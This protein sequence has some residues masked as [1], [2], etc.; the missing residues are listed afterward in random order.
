VGFERMKYRLLLL[1]AIL[2]AFQQLE[3]DITYWVWER[4]KPLSNEELADLKAARVTRL[5]WQVGTLTTDGMGWKWREHFPLYWIKINHNRDIL[6]IIP[7][8]RLEP[9][10]GEG[11]PTQSFN[12]LIT[13]LNSLERD[14]GAGELQIDYECPDRLIPNYVDFLK[15]LK[16]SGRTW[17]L[18]ISALGHWAK[19]TSEFEGLADEI[20]PMFYDLNP[21]RERLDTGA[22]P[23][24]FN[25]ESAA[26]E[27]STWKNCPLPWR[28]GIPNFSRLTLVSREGVSAG[29]VRQW[30]WDEVWFSTMLQPLSET[31]DGET[32][33]AV[34]SASILGTTPL[35]AGESVVARYPDRAALSSILPTV[36]ASGAEGVIYFRM[37]GEDDMSGYSVRDISQSKVVETGFQVQTDASTRITLNNLS[38]SDL[39]PDIFTGNPLQ[40]GYC[41][42]VRAD[43]PIWRDV[44]PGDFADASMDSNGTTLR[45]RFAHLAAGHIL[46]TGLV[47]RAPEGETAHVQ[48]RVEPVEKENV[49]HDLNSSPR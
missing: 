31:I 13:T 37:A 28:A 20:T 42:V 22:L 29:N 30:N 23:P 45:F 10:G 5:Y 35:Q 18:S 8:L 19:Y 26:G 49:W 47:E 39:M 21:D 32:C 1:L 25:P 3:G 2:T 40:R 38:T 27:I 43:S 24:L 34:K 12:E 36:A 17:R 48:W 16:E 6:S 33:F 15:R 41:L 7:V 46:S 11:L 14:S 44:L 4:S 9:I